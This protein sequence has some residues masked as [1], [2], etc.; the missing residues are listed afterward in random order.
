MKPFGIC[1]RCEYSKDCVV[2]TETNAR[3]IHCVYRA[4][5]MKGDVH[6]G[7]G[8][9]IQPAKNSLKKA[10]KFNRNQRVKK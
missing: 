1:A 10:G 8:K 4:E 2:E 6:I 9:K 5:F 3:V 7:K